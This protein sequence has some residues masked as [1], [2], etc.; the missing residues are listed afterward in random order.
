MQN[1]SG[2]LHDCLNLCHPV[3]QPQCGHGIAGSDAEF[4]EKM[5]DAGSPIFNETLLIPREARSLH[6][7]TIGSVSLALA[8]RPLPC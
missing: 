1:K 8:R 5:I 6:W 2:I 4:A 3:K 7:D